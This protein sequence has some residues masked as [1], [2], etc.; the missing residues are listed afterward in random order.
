MDG[1]TVNPKITDMLHQHSKFSLLASM[2][3]N[4]SAKSTLCVGIDVSKATLD[5]AATSEFSSLRVTTLMALM[6]LLLSLESIRGVDSDGDHW[7]S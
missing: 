6:P 3:N 4:E 1:C 5:I 7:R 2:G